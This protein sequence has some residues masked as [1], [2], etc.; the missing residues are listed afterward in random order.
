MP[1]DGDEAGAGCAA[2]PEH[3]YPRGVHCVCPWMTLVIDCRGNVGNE[4]GDLT[5]TLHNYWRQCRYAA[6]DKRLKES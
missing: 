6:D 3:P 5:W 1:H 2:L 4:V